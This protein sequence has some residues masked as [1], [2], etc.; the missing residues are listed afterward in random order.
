MNTFPI[1]TFKLL[2]WEQHSYITQALAIHVILYYTDI[3]IY[4]AIRILINRPLISVK[5]IAGT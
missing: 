5:K 2:N 3:Y 4:I 1:Q